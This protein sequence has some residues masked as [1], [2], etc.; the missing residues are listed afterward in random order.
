MPPVCHPSQWHLYF[1]L[2][3]YSEMRDFET[4]SQALISRSRKA[5]MSSRDSVFPEVTESTS[6]VDPIG[7][8]AFVV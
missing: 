5:F 1:G 7:Y 4:M 3:S 2:T 8:S 6:K